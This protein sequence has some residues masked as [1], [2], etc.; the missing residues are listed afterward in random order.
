MKADALSSILEGFDGGQTVVLSAEARLTV[1]Q[2]LENADALFRRSSVTSGSR[3]ALCGLAGFDLITALAA[4]DG[5]VRAMLLLPASA[6]SASGDRLVLAAGCTHMMDGEGVRALPDC[7]EACGSS[8]ADATQW[9]LATSGT[10]GVPKVIGHTLA[11]LSRTVKRDVVKSRGFIWGLL[12]DPCRFAG[13]QVILQALLAGSML[14]VSSS[15]DFDRQVEGLVA[16]GV[17]A[18]SATPSLWRKL[19]MDGRIRGCQLRQ[20]TLG[21]EIADQLLLDGLKHCFPAARIVHIYASTEVGV[22]FSVHDG[23]AG[24]PAPWLENERA[25]VPMMVRGDG[26]LLVR[27]ATVPEWAEIAGRLDAD[28]YL[29]TGDLVRVAGD[30]VF[31]SGRASGA[32]NVGGNKV[33]PEYV[34][35]HIRRV[36]GVF[37]VCVYGK[38]S[39]MM[40]QI[41]AADIVPDP[42]VDMA[43]L[44]LDILNYCRSTLENWQIPGILRFVS[45]LQETPAGKRERLI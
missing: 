22:G 20:I 25:P 2:L 7:R 37:D 41:V 5:R 35:E 44:R 1:D 18:L 29:D 10:T 34:E 26:H 3:I 14:S 38:T 39:S 19:L 11:S 24:F 9:L 32:V 33:M 15:H 8:D 40:G 16:G 31:F 45:G 23:L 36:N 42:G 28:G 13:L 27:P 17:N 21:G 12:Y 43:G 6:D 4:F 30:R